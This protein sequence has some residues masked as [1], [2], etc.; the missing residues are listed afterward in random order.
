VLKKGTYVGVDIQLKGKTALVMT[1]GER[2]PRG[3]VPVGCVM[4]QADDV[5]TGYGHGWHEFPE[6]DWE[7]KIL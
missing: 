5:S 3:I 6:S 2:S 4:I 1:V 7:I